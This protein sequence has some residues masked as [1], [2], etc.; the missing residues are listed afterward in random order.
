MFDLD[1]TL[2]HFEFEGFMRAYLAAVGAR[3]A[4]V[5]DPRRFVSQLLKS[6]EAMM[7]NLDP[8]RTNQEVFM[9]DFFSK[10][11]LPQDVLMPV[12][13]SFYREDFPNLAGTLGI[14][15]L[16]AARPVLEDLFRRGYEVVIATNPVFPRVAT[17]ER[18]RW[19]GIGDLPFRLVTVYEDCH[20]CKPNPEYYEEVLSMIG[21][22]PEECIMVGNDVDEDLAAGELG[23]KTYLVEDCLMGSGALGFKPD[24][25]GKFNDLVGFFISDEFAKL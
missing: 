16:P 5:M 23:I 8:N 12:I 7:A 19:G 6:T 3:V 11:D 18:L 9:E 25:R 17:E 2:I 24:Y 10:M 14:R 20:F 15:P 1:G 13:D 21:R 4:P 22:K